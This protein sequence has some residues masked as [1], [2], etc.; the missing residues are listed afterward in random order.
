LCYRESV[1]RTGTARLG[2]LT[3]LVG[4]GYFAV[5][6]VFGVIVFPL[7][8]LLA[9]I[10]I[11]EPELSRAVP[12]TVGA[13]LLIA[14]VLQHTGWKA[15]HL[16]FCR[17]AAGFRLTP[18]ASAGAAWR[19]G[20]RLGLHCSQSCAGPTAVVL[21]LGV[22]D[23]RVMAAVATAITV[24]RLAPNGIRVARAIGAVVVAVG[25]LAIARAAG[26]R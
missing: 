25:V 14:G 6:G 10:A 26:L 13:A 22:M 1:G 23:V 12:I 8:L 18:P 7:G 15:R 3:V 19:H 16:T 4:V 5:W 24:E 2:L 20:L 21:G 17:E 11:R 9:D